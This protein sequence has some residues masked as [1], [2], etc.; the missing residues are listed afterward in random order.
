MKGKETKNISHKTN[1]GGIIFLLISIY[2]IGYFMVMGWKG[3][4]ADPFLLILAMIY[5]S[6]GVIFWGLVIWTI[7]ITAFL[8]IRSAKED[9]REKI[10]EKERKIND[11]QEQ[12]NRLKEEL[13][14]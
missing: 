9:A 14:K 7:C 4:L 3:N 2:Y 8:L 12:I 10:E 5:S 13:I 6:L 11:L 1:V